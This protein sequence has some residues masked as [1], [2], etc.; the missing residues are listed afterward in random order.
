[1]TSVVIS[2]QPQCTPGARVWS[3]WI[4]HAIEAVIDFILIDRE[5]THGDL[6]ND[7][8]TCSTAQSW[9]GAFWGSLRINCC[10]TTHNLPRHVYMSDVEYVFF[11]VLQWTRVGYVSRL[12]SRDMT[13]V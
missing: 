5:Y 12:Q 6:H 9:Y 10:V 3:S 13:P 1:M 11:C 4:I 7:S 2:N 8:K